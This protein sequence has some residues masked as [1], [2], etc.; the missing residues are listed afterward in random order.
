MAIQSSTSPSGH[1]ICTLSA[2]YLLCSPSR[3]ASSS[4]TTHKLSLQ[5]QTQIPLRDNA[6]TSADASY[7]RTMMSKYKNKNTGT[8][9]AAAGTIG[10]ASAAGA[11]DPVAC[12]I[13]DI[14][15]CYYSL[16][17]LPTLDPSPQ[18]DALFGQLVHSCRQTSS[19]ATTAKV[20]VPVTAHHPTRNRPL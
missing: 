19:D 14:L 18:V 20:C 13:S 1:T 17:N 3:I 7:R 8:T 5:G 11:G 15:A 9:I 6:I 2:Y 12:L 10:I 16:S 4:Q